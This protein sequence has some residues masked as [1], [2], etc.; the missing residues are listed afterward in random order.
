MDLST[1]KVLWRQPGTMALWGLPYDMRPGQTPYDLWKAHRD[2]EPPPPGWY[3][4]KQISLADW[5]YL[6]S[7]G[8]HGAIP[9]D[10]Q[11][12]IQAFL[13]AH[14]DDVPHGPCEWTR[15]P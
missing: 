4:S 3:G 6:G 8:W 5:V 15:I 1:I 12:A 13:E 2:Y 10:E 14:K 9:Q 11:V 7:P